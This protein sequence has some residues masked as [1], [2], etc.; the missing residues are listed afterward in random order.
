MS[1]ELRYTDDETDQHKQIMRL[2]LS[3]Q[4]DDMQYQWDFFF[5]SL[6]KLFYD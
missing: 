4:K 6:K 5:V 1:S 2:R 3:N